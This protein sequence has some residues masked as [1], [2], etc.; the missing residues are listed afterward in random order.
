MVFRV[1]TAENQFFGLEFG[2]HFWNQCL[3]GCLFVSEAFSNYHGGTNIGPSKKNLSN[4]LTNMQKQFLG[5]C[6]YWAFRSWLFRQE[7][8]FLVFSFLATWVQDK[9]L[10]EIY[11]PFC[12]VNSSV[13]TSGLCLYCS[14]QSKATHFYALLVIYSSVLSINFEVSWRFSKW[15]TPWPNCDLEIVYNSSSTEAICFPGHSFH[16]YQA[17]EGVVF[18]TVRNGQ[19]G[20][21]STEPC[22]LVLK[23]SSQ[24]SPIRMW[25][26]KE[27][28]GDTFE[29]DRNLLLW[30][31]KLWKKTTIASSGQPFLIDVRLTT[32]RQN[33]KPWREVS[34]CQWLPQ[35]LSQDCV[36]D[37]SDI[38][39]SFPKYV[40][41]A[42]ILSQGVP[43][44]C[45][46]ILSSTPSWTQNMQDRLWDYV[47]VPVVFL[48]TQV[49]SEHW[50]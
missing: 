4:P 2:N 42:N 15:Y 11:A 50:R 6:L 20:R 8:F 34:F 27:Q 47:S 31:E 18:C 48:I 46:I 5:F 40:R 22:Y 38:L 35:D 16:A 33:D 49:L 26:E 45:V 23:S 3:D 19:W 29:P 12:K 30:R 37:T 1:S 9:K 17:P 24:T 41:V 43:T 32:W 36:P 39:I 13:L 14:S 28:I 21:K 7:P 25:H 10:T 44:L